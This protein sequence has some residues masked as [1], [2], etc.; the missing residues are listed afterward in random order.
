MKVKNFKTYQWGTY[1]LEV[2]VNGQMFNDGTYKV[3]QKNSQKENQKTI[4]RIEALVAHAQLPESERKA[5]LTFQKEQ[6]NYYDTL[7][8]SVWARKDSRG[9][10]SATMACE[11]RPSEGYDARVTVWYPKK[12]YKE[13]RTERGMI[14]DLI[15]EFNTQ[16]KWGI[17]KNFVLVPGN[18]FELVDCGGKG[19][20]RGTMGYLPNFSIV[21]KPDYTKE[22]CTNVYTPMICSS[23]PGPRK[24]IPCLE[25]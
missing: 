2:T 24:E 5:L 15:E 25:G 19:S 11:Y 17:N 18:E 7:H 22:E 13:I 21:Y 20:G 16:G 14:G 3:S 6:R 8:P 9:W 4:K 12:L 1:P 23:T 10:E